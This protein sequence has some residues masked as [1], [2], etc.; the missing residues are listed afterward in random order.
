MKKQQ[1]YC[2]ATAANS[3]QSRPRNPALHTPAWFQKSR[4]PPAAQTA[5]RPVCPST[6]LFSNLKWKVPSA[7]T[8]GACS[9]SEVLSKICELFVRLCVY[10]GLNSHMLDHTTDKG[11]ENHQNIPG[12]YFAFVRMLLGSCVRCYCF[13]LWHVHGSEERWWHPQGG[14]STK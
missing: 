13:Y 5:K 6:F 11:M 2:N 10:D 14:I 12:L 7:Q 3:I 8:G 1:A 9:V 4:A